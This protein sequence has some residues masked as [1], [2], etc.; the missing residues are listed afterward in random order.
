MTLYMQSPVAIGS[1][2]YRE[3]PG[4]GSAILRRRFVPFACAK[5]DTYGEFENW[6]SV[7]F[8]PICL[9]LVY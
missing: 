9:L 7:L 5:Y 3:S 6:I 1:C 2:Q 4:S 8:K